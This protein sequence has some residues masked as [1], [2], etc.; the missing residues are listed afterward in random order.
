MI[1][2]QH[3][4]YLNLSGHQAARRTISHKRR[5]GMSLRCS[6]KL[7]QWIPAFLAALLSQTTLRGGQVS[8]RPARTPRLVLLVASH[9]SIS[10]R[11]F[12]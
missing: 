4:R 11:F 7:S 8:D 1:T 6:T 10:V 12:I 3:D 9:D 5:K 2:S